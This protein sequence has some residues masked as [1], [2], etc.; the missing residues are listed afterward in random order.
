MKKKRF[1]KCF[2]LFPSVSEYYEMLR[3]RS[4]E[5]AIIFYKKYKH[6]HYGH[7]ILYLQVIRILNINKKKI[8]LLLY[9]YKSQFTRYGY[10]IIMY[11]CR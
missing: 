8:W 2:S 9:L 6:L 3:R 1:K 5:Y 10:L 11:V 4:K 7:H